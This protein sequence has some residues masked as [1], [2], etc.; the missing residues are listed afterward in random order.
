MSIMMMMMMM[1][2]MITMNNL[3]HGDAVTSGLANHGFPDTLHIHLAKTFSNP[4]PR[5]HQPDKAKDEN[6]LHILAI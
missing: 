2:M 6:S 4:L 3:E 5:H 1:I